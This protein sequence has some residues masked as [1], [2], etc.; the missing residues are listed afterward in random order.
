MGGSPELVAQWPMMF[1]RYIALGDSMSIDDYPGFDHAERL[2]QTGSSPGLGA[3]SLLYQNQ[4]AV[5]PEFVGADLASRCP[6]LRASR[7]AFDGATT[8][9]VIDLQ[10]P[11]VE[12]EKDGLDTLVTLTAGGNDLL[13][14]L[15]QSQAEA[16]RVWARRSP[17]SSVSC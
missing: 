2:G 9:G 17:T 6:G 3:A 7:E 8:Q 11:S 13:R 10:L 14:L 15:G 5:W 12:T 4:D 1:R 16:N